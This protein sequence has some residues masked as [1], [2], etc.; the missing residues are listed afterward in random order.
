MG[1]LLKLRIDGQDVQAPAGTNL[2][3]AAEMAGVH[4]P[5]LCYLKGM[6]GIGACRMCL[7]EVE[8][9]KAPVIACNT[10]VKQDMVVHTRTERVQEIRRF[11]IDLILSMHP[12]D[13][14]TCTKSGVC[15]LQEYAYEFGLRESSFS[16]K[17]FTYPV[18]DG[19]PFVKRDP[20][21]CILCG[22]CVRVCKEQGTNVLDFMGRGIESKVITANDMPLHESGC[23][24]CGSCVD[25]CPVSALREADREQKG[26][27]WEFSRYESVCMLCGCGCDIT[28]SIKGDMIQK[29]N[30]GNRAPSTEQKFIC[31]YGRFGYEHID[32][33][34][35][36]LAPM[37]RK[38]GRLQEV[39]MKDALEDLAGRLKKA[40]K[41][42][43]FISTASILNEDALSLQRFAEEVVKTP[44]IDSTASLYARP[45]E[46]QK[47]QKAKMDKADLI[48]LVGINPSQWT[49][50]LPALDVA[51]RRRLSRKG[52]LITINSQETGLADLAELNLSGDEIQ[53]I[54]GI[55]KSVPDH[56]IKVDQ[57]LMK[58]VQEAST[59]KNMQQA[60]EIFAGSSSPLI[61][62]DPAF[63][64]AASSLAGI[65][66]HAIAMPLESNAHGVVRM[67]LKTR[68]AS[69]QDMAAIEHGLV[70]RG[71]STVKFL[72]AVGDVPLSKKPDGV[73]FLVV[74]S[75]SLTGLAG[76]ADMVL[77]AAT[78]LES[79]GSMVDYLGELK[80]MEQTIEPRGAS[81]T[82][83]DIFIQL[84]KNMGVT[85]K[86]PPFSEIKKAAGSQAGPSM[87]DMSRKEGFQET[88]ESYLQALN[89]PVL[90]TSRLLWLKES[91]LV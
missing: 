47:S 78:Y 49:R 39:S 7:V 80:T 40:G 42:A 68:G 81:K 11:V 1:K 17:K 56:G 36:I 19:N 66:G 50:V 57:S 31:A 16:R 60:A 34:K 24:F 75:S 59:D 86:K 69:I 63:F 45:E 8:G 52:R 21:Y 87:A 83:R 18:D 43:G 9:L 14:V 76:E 88:P 30:A 5:N 65:K 82:H 72:Y 85:L 10:R 84:A 26:R 38:G 27:E 48:V 32:G 46:F 73:D 37:V 23:T 22:R 41:N 91:G 35:R 71:K 61:I 20:A 25:V 64:D 51:V 33:G 15:N 58:H 4:I 28:V 77:P 74:Q 13:C 53:A 62:S 70:Q 29:I 90:E 6:K 2:I 3:D 55:I 67:G 89:A 54:Q 44:N 12:L 79:S